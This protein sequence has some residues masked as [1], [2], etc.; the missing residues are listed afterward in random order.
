MLQSNSVL[1]P[2]GQ[3]QRAGQGTS[4]GCF[5]GEPGKL[6]EGSGGIVCLLGTF[7]PLQR[8]VSVSQKHQS[9]FLQ[10]ESELL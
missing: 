4:I 9:P 6:R 3:L 1:A 10:Q 7:R 5:N 2:Q 8:D